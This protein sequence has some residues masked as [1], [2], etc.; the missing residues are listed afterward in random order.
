[1][2]LQKGCVKVSKNKN[3]IKKISH[4]IQLPPPPPQKKRWKS[5]SVVG[6]INGVTIEHKGTFI[7]NFIFRF[8][9]F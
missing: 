6:Y 5:R 9:R 2:P 4:T 7:L 8:L 1:M 3:K